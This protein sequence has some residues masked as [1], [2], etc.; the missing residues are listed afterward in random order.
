M[1]LYTAHCITKLSTGPALDRSTQLT[2]GI[3][4][5]CRAV[6]VFD[7]WKWG[8]FARFLTHFG[9]GDEGRSMDHK[10]KGQ[11]LGHVL[12]DCTSQFV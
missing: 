7:G 5:K 1:G 4:G 12:A 6:E 8:H 3:R 10:G 11:G 9:E 2:C